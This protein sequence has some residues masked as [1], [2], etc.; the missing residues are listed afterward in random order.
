MR[1][2]EFISLLG[3]VAVAWPVAARAQQPAVPVIG[4]L[5]STSPAA[6]AP[7]LMA[8]RQGLRE[9]GYVEGQNVTIEYRWAGSDYARLPTL[10]ADLVRQHVAVIVA[11]GGVLL[12]EMEGKRLG[13]LRDMVST[14]HLI[15]ALLN[16]HSPVSASELKDV[17]QA[18]RAVGQQIHILNASSEYDLDAAFASLVP[19]GAGALLVGSDPFFNSRR[20]Y[21]V[22]LAARASIP[23]IYE[24]REFVVAGGLMSYGTNL[25]N[26]YRQVGLYTGRILKGEKPHDLPVV[27]SSK[28]EFA[29]N[30]KTAKTLGLD[31][32]LRLQQLA[33]EVIE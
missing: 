19:V 8:F 32:P 1:R 31:V 28:F 30:L 17:Q 33:D 4:L 21:L 29:I 16:P 23:A 2:R 6:W 13:L 24:A 9:A 11:V 20:D 7:Y 25:A 14:A 3:G 27:Q 10:A 12:A 15:A 18:A 26:G 5:G 22:S